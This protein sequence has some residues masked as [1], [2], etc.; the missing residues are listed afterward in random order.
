VVELPKTPP[1]S[2]ELEALARR[3]E[4]L[5]REA[6]ADKLCM[7]VFS[8]ELD[9]QL[10]ALIMATGAAASGMEV[11]L[12]FT[13]WATASLRDPKK[14]TSKSFMGRM[15]GWMLP[16]GSRKLKLSKMQLM[17]MGPMMIRSRMK[18]KGVASVEDLLEIAGE[19]GVRIR[20]CTMSMDIM[21]LKQEEFIQY[22]ELDYCGVAS[23]VEETSTA[24]T[25]LFI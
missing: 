6:P 12:F 9:R 25:T 11:C 23:F 16:R 8:G 13:F 3:V 18:K 15:F 14:Q 7:C 24:K 1:N 2:S 20:I 5:E 17:G 21:E 22:P 10:A 4:H 19:L